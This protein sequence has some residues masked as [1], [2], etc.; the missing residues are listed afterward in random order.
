MHVRYTGAALCRLALICLPHP[1][2]LHSPTHPLHTPTHPHSPPHLP[3]VTVTARTSR[4]PRV[5]SA[6]VC[7]TRRSVFLTLGG[8][9]LMCVRCP[10]V[11]IWCRMSMNS[12]HPRLWRLDASVPIRCVSVCVCV[13]MYVCVCVFVELRTGK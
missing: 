8:R 10:C 6:G 2:P 3:T 1:H 9:K 12:C 7:L 11:Y 4:T 13:C 5:G